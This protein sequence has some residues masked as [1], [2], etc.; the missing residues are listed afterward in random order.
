MLP[1]ESSTKRNRPEDY[2]PLDK[3][4]KTT[5]QTKKRPAVR[6]RKPRT[7]TRGRHVLRR[8]NVASRDRRQSSTPVS[9]TDTCP[10]TITFRDFLVG[11]KGYVGLLVFYNILHLFSTTVAALC[12]VDTGFWY[13]MLALNLC[14]MS[15]LLYTPTLGYVI[16]KKLKKCVVSRHPG[17]ESD[18]NGV[19]V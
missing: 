15:G 13:S 7:L 5:S 3:K 9:N 1:K 17:A 14:F 12:D 16:C 18:V 8:S 2:V 10:S 4:I 19:W 6:R 11:N